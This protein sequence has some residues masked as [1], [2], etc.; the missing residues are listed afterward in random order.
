MQKEI[1]ISDDEYETRCAILEDGV[2]AEFD[3]E[4][5]NHEH[6]LNNIYKGRVETVL[7][8]M[9]IAFVDIGLER[10][11]FLHVSDI[12]ANGVESVETDSTKL[13]LNPNST[14]SPKS[15]RGYPYSIGDLIQKK[16]EILVQVGKESMG[17][18]GPRVTSCITLAGRYVVYLP[19]A[20]NI[21]ISRRISSAEE[22]QRLRDIAEAMRADI[23]GGFIIRTAAEGKSE[24]EFSTEIRYLV[25][26][27]QK[28]VER[29]EGMPVFSLVHK[30]HGFIV[31]I[32]R[33]VFTN[34]VTQF[35][36]DSKEQYQGTLSYLSSSA[37]PELQSRVKF[38]DKSTP[39]FEN[40]G[41]E[42]E[43]KKAL[44][45]KI[46]L[47]C[48]GYIVIQQTEAMVSIDVNTG[49]FV[50]K[51]DPDNTI[52]SANLEAVQEVVRQI[53]LR[54]LGGIIVIDFIDMD[55]PEHRKMVFKLLQE[56][57][58]KDRARTNLL[59]ISELGL[60]EMTRQRTR[61][62]LATVLTEECPY[63]NGAGRVLSA[64]TITIEVLRSIKAAFRK[65]RKRRLKLVANDHIVSNLLD[66]K[67]DRLGQ[68]QKSMNLK[69]RLQ[70]DVDLHLE[71]YRI[72][73]EDTNREIYLD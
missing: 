7:P 10:H 15:G 11:A 53:R 8:G 31:R 1:I 40:Y 34:D 63:C 20:S 73:A 70:G 71:D 46:W 6:V 72:F 64:D 16:Q 30:D 32:I 51:G 22:K 4:R 19:T 67:P 41:I 65:S 28:I 44:G 25:N 5:K 62:S 29:A 55:H 43:L 61:P 18:K 59:H 13:D 38:Y 12:R 39:I 69:V 23:E 66:D 36:V 27:W 47:K 14:D 57:L 35:V 2:L 33:D 58:N 56:I 54:D 17:T 50:G 60:V 49:K 37:L 9:Q 52:L 24:A 26:Q 48:G 45:E 68:L 21:G 42:K 3:I